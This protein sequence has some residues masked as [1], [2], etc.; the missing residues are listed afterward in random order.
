MVQWIKEVEMATSIDDLMTSQSIAGRRDFT[1]YEMLDAKVAS[2]LKKIIECALPKEC[3]RRRAT[4]SENTND[5]YEEG[6]LHNMIYE[7]FRASGAYEAVKGLSDLFK[8][9][10]T[11]DHVQDCDTKFDQARLAASEMPTETVLEGLYK[12]K[13]QDSVQLHTVLQ[14]WLCMN[15]RTSEIM[16]H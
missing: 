9:A 2:T 7:H 1:D 15:K 10:S 5:S 13:L 14:Y 12:F 6:R 16:N 8:K 11:D 3:Q 4:R